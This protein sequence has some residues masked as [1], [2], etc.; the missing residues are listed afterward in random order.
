MNETRKIRI[1]QWSIAL[2]LLCNIG[3]IVT[4]WFRPGGRGKNETP[5]DFVI[6]SLR[7]T[8]E[9]IDQYDVL[10]EA[11]QRA[12]RGL[13]QEARGTRQ[14]LFMGL[15]GGHSQTINADSLAA[16]I[17]NT[18]GKIEKVTYDHFAEVRKIC[19]D[20]QKSEFDHIIGDVIKKMN[21]GPHGGPGPGGD[22]PDRHGPPPGE[23]PPPGQ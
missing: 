12:M 3:L 20:A 7:F 6:R 2:L 22:G 13:R 1:L 14:Q 10:I 16:L 19:N 18:Q 21:G 5:R 15:E 9:Q 8:D 4:M 23:G 17:G 11:H